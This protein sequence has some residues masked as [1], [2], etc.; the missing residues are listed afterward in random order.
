[1]DFPKQPQSTFHFFSPVTSFHMQT[2]DMHHPKNV[3]LKWAAHYHS[4]V[5]CIKVL[6]LA[7]LPFFFSA[8]LTLTHSCQSKSHDLCSTALS[9]EP[10]W[11]VLFSAVAREGILSP[12]GWRKSPLGAGIVSFDLTYHL[13]HGRL[14][15][16]TCTRW[17]LIV[18][19]QLSM[20]FQ[21]AF[22]AVA[23]CSGSS[24]ALYR[25]I[26]KVVLICASVV[27]SISSVRSHIHLTLCTDSPSSIPISHIFLP[28]CSSQLSACFHITHPT[29]VTNS[30]V[31]WLPWTGL[32]QCAGLLIAS[33]ELTRFRNLR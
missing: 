12:S 32:R 13:H 17:S 9:R 30:V 29:I 27:N 28:S 19:T 22:Y 15:P 14:H 6:F 8:Q 5:T 16:M 24:Q 11:A 3:F 18:D 21:W 25:C 4:Q 2:T 26:H 20:Y 23:T 31:L 10:L 33:S 1:M 7:G